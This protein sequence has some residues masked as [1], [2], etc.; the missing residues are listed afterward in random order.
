MSW[1]STEGYFILSSSWVWLVFMP[2]SESVMSYWW[3]GWTLASA[4]ARGLTAALQV[5]FLWPPFVGKLFWWK[6][7]MDNLWKPFY[8]GKLLLL[9]KVTLVLL[10][11]SHLPAQSRGLR[12]P[13]H[14]DWTQGVIFAFI[15]WPYKAKF[16]FKKKKIYFSMCP[17][18]L[19]FSLL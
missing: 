17:Q 16:L 12:C 18:T 10:A 1:K 13:L 9:A 7:E 14:L 4:R 15:F 11:V 6:L 19:S 8:E 3:M 2:Q 5:A